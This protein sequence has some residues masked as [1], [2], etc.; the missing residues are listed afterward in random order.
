MG[1][2]DRSVLGGGGNIVE[3]LEYHIRVL[4]LARGT[5][6]DHDV[7][8]QVQAEGVIVG[9]AYYVGI[10]GL[11]LLASHQVGTGPA[12]G[13]TEYLAQDTTAG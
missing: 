1:V 3:C 2:G 12:E 4:V 10:V 6:T 7:L 9:T 8:V 11:G 13:G 5:Q